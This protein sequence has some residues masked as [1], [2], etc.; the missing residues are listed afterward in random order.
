MAETQAKKRK[1]SA[2]GAN[3][4]DLGGRV[5]P[6]NIEMERAALCSALLSKTGFAR[7][8]NY[9]EAESFY[10]HKH[11]LIFSAMKRLHDRGVAIDGLTVS[12]ELE[13][14][15][16][17]ETAGGDLYLAELSN[18][19]ATAAHAEDYAKKVLD[20]YL[21][22]RLIN[23]ATQAVLEA[24]EAP[25]APELID[26][27]LKRLFEVYSSRGAGGFE[28]LRDILDKT[29][30][31]FKETQATEGGVKGIGTGYHRL[32]DLTSGFQRGDLVI[33]AARPSM[34]KTA[35]SLCLARNACKLHKKKVGFFS[36]EMSS[37]AI[38]MRLLALEGRINLHRLRSGKLFD[39]EFP[40]LAEATENLWDYDFFVDD[41]S[42]L[43]LM[44]MRARSLMLK[45]QH[46][47]DIIFIDYL[48]LM[49][50][51]KIDSR[52][53]QVAYISR[54]LKA[55]A[56]ELDIPVVALSQLSRAVEGRGDK[57]PQLSDLRDSGAIE[58]DADLVMFIYREAVYTKDEEKETNEDGVDTNYKTV[59][60]SAE[61]LIRKQ[62]NGP[63]GKDELIFVPDYATFENPSDQAALEHAETYADK[64]SPSD[65][66]MPF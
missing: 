58:Q 13:N 35:F 54:G 28:N 8:A 34:G 31:E 14:L 42:G 18:E 52:E 59:D 26:T 5:Q 45:Q 23:T 65:E 19:V 60:N 15:G 27:T 53:Q 46:N 2:G 21:L 1:K 40:K 38:A 4:A 39:R 3:F 17:L 16:D 48:G 32:D 24:Y 30:E 29:H 50:P 51:P 49:T 25:E 36:L 37:I 6:N 61:I 12:D 44:E 41:T 33:I 47:V 10:D 64:S 11:R 22:R 20:K 56:R 66:D 62:R 43:S 57:R 63:T 7:I 55:L 9:L